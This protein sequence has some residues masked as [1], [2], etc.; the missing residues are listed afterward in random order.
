MFATRNS[1]EQIINTTSDLQQNLAFMKMLNEQFAYMQLPLK[2]SQQNAH[3]DLYVM[4]RKNAL[5]KSKDNLKV[6]LHLE[7][8]SLGTL[9]KITPTFPLNFIPRKKQHGNFWKKMWNY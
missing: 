9:Q 4:T 2:L 8:D 5:K 7:M 3:G 1:G 6:L